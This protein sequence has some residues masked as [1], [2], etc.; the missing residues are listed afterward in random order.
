MKQDVTITVRGGETTYTA[1]GTMEETPSGWRLAY[2]EPADNGMA[3][4]STA[5]A[6]SD[7][8]AVLTRVGAVRC[9]MVFAQGE[10]HASVYETPFGKST[11]EVRTQTLR[12][13]LGAHG[14]VV[15]L[16]YALVLGGA[17]SERRLKILVKTTEGGGE[18]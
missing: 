14:G 3:G 15:E 4:T 16:R 12:A 8:R 7:G 5:L 9:E 2:D 1:P 18:T 17:R 6:V 13:R 11:V 10:T